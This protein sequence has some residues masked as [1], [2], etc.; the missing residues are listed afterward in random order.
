MPNF[1]SSF[2]YL[3][4]YVLCLFERVRYIRLER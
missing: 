2:R 1:K 3:R 4:V